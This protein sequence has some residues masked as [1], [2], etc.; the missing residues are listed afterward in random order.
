MIDDNTRFVSCKIPAVDFELTKHQFSRSEETSNHTAACKQSSTP[1][2]AQRQKE[3][4]ATAREKQAVA[5]PDCGV[6]LVRLGHCFTCPV[7][8][9]GGCS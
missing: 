8:G 7:C 3:K 9:Y 6:G 5:C 1:A 2:I 4:R